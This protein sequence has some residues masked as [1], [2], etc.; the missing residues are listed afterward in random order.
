MFVLCLYN[1]KIHQ[2]KIKGDFAFLEVNDE[3]ISGKVKA[4][5][6]KTGALRDANI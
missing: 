3:L 4:N 6:D 1:L 5:L 2:K